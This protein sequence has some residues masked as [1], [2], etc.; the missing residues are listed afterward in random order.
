[1]TR[2]AVHHAIAVPNGGRLLQVEE[3]FPARG[4]EIVGTAVSDDRRVLFVRKLSVC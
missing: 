2:T 1:V 4:G 3:R